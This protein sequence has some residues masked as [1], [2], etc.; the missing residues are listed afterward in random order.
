M[1]EC[2]LV[3]GDF[4]PTNILVRNGRVTGILD[5]EF[6]HA[7]TPYMDIGNLLRNIDP[8]HHDDI[9]RGLES[10]GMRLPHDWQVR[11]ALIDLGSHLEFLTSQRSDDF[12]RLCV[13]RIKRFIERF[14]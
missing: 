5:W 4:N 3:H 8:T 1:A 10:G 14:E 11:A 7:N 13:A 2:G 6:A 12:K 9:A